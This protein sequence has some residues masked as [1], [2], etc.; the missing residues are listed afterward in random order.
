M[1]VPRITTDLDE[2]EKAAR[3]S[4]QKLMEECREDLESRQW[5]RDEARRRSLP[6]PMDVSHKYKP[7]PS[8]P[9]PPLPPTIR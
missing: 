7:D 8:L 3:A 5:E 9:P 2:W 6:D 1:L 4:Q